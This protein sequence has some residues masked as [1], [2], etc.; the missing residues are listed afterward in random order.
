MLLLNNE[1]VK[2]LLTVNMALEALEDVHREQAFGRA[3]N[4]LRRDV[5]MPTELSGYE[6]VEYDFKTMLGIV[7]KLGIAALRIS[8]KIL[9]TSVLNNIERRIN[10]P[11]AGGDSFV[12]LVL[13]FSTRNTEPLAI[14]PDGYLQGMRVGCTFA[15]AAK[16]LAREDAKTIGLFGSGHQARFQLLAHCQVLPIDTVKVYS[17]DPLHRRQFA[18]RMSLELGCPVITLD[19]PSHVMAGVDIVLSATNSSVP[20]IDP[21]GIEPGMHLA[22]VASE[23]LD[24]RVARRVDLIGLASTERYEIYTGG[25]GQYGSMRRKEGDVFDPAKTVL[26][27]DLI[28]GKV[29]GRTRRDQTTLFRSGSGMGI[30]FVA[31]AAKIVEAAMERKVGTELPTEWF[32]QL[33]HS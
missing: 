19:E 27:E 7:P 18:E 1:E 26:L 11:A 15:L 3:V 5:R 29:E 28:A 13:A 21:E 31:M 17:P 12:G 22:A 4:S 32:T 23:E 30:Q 9:A 20:V 33:L 2:E 6:R 8:S 14:F 24:E 16:Y 25:T 10:V